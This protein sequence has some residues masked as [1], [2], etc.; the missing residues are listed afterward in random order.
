VVL[1]L[2]KNA[3]AQLK[4]RKG[5]FGKVCRTGEEA[6]KEKFHTAINHFLHL[7]LLTINRLSQRFGKGNY[8]R[9]GKS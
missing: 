3:V 8:E 2:K 6:D 1:R 4:K 9:G 5:L 7:E